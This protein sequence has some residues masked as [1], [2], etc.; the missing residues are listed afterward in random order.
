MKILVAHGLHWFTTRETN[1]SLHPQNHHYV[2]MLNHGTY[3]NQFYAK[4]I[5]NLIHIT[6]TTNCC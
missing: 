3:N 2:S 6:A 1:Q 4:Y 5:T